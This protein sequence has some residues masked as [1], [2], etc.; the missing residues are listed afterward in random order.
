MTDTFVV[1]GGAGFVGS[2]LVD[3]LLAE[4]NRVVAID[5]LSAGDASRVNTEADFE[6]LDIDD[7]QALDSVL[8]AA[9]PTVI[10]HLAAQSSIT[11]S[12]KNP[13][14]DCDVNVRGTL[15]LLEAANRIQAPLVFTS[16]AGALYGNVAPLP[17]PERFVP[18]PIAPYGASKWA[19]EAYINTWANSSRL[20]HTVLR[21]ANVYGARQSPGGEVGVVAI[22][23]YALWRGQRARMYGHGKP[24]RDYIQVAD[25]VEAMIRASGVRG[26][27]N[28]STGFETSVEDVYSTLAGEAESSIEPELL[29]LRDGEL[30]RSC[31]DPSHAERTLG[32]RARIGVKDGLRRTHRE[33]VAEFEAREPAARG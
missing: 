9:S 19:A 22:F 27:F 16:S 1:T 25:V 5:D 32:W 2:H 21:L 14:R 29:P 18:S 10:Y 6:T 28:V 24:T 13:R 7:P 15:N 11:K 3:A 12:V 30:R 17:T 31:I 20:P 4:G 8:D 26:T 23:S 33:L